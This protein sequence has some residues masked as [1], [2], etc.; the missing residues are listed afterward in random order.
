M[1]SFSNENSWLY[2]DLRRKCRRQSRQ[3]TDKRLLYCWLLT[4]YFKCVVKITMKDRRV[5]NTSQQI[6]LYWVVII[7]ISLGFSFESFRCHFSLWRNCQPER[8]QK[9]SLALRTDRNSLNVLLTKDSSE[10]LHPAF[11]SVTAKIL[12]TFKTIDRRFLAH[13]IHSF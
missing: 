10:V 2:D 5:E 8:K 6:L 1:N 13:S 11:N 7:S 9:C 3:F 4:R 12:C